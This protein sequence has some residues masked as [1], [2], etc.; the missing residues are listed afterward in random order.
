MKK[1]IIFI[2]VCFCIVF[3]VFADNSVPIP[4]AWEMV[5]QTDDI[6]TAAKQACLVYDGIG[7]WEDA[8]FQTVGLHVLNQMENNNTITLQLYTFH[9]VY[10]VIDGKIKQVAA[11]E[12]PVQISFM[13]NGDT[14]LLTQYQMPRDGTDYGKDLNSIFG[15]ALAYNIAENSIEYSEIAE[16]DALQNAEK[17]ISSNENEKVSLPCIAFLKSGTNQE[18]EKI[19]LN[20]ISGW[21]PSHIGKYISYNYNTMYKLSV[22]GEQSFSGILTYESFNIHGERLDFAKVQVDGKKLNVLDGKL[23]SME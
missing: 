23:P 7:Y 20:N 1:F 18:A 11:G 22:E 8:K 16:R 13:R 14:F 10:D 17:Y 3:S 19:I 2:L 6:I 15:K 12:I 5:F 9:G 21:F 4:T